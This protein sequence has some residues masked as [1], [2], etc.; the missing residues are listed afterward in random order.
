MIEKDILDRVEYSEESPSGLVWSKGRKYKGSNQ[1]GFI[2]NNTFDKKSWRTMIRNKSFLCHRLIWEKVVGEIPDGF[3]IDHIDQNPL[4]NRIEN[5]RVVRGEENVRNKRRYKT[6]NG[7]PS[8]VNLFSNQSGNI[9]YC[10]SINTKS[11]AGRVMKYFS[12]SKLGEELA[13]LAAT[14]WRDKMVRILNL[15]GFGYSSLHGSYRD[16]TIQ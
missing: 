10:S 1:V 2:H 5:L 13:L 12:I 7:L 4:N 8:G 11:G 14:E 6:S 3:Q 16:K 15:R 9:Y